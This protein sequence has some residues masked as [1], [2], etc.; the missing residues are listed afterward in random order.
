MTLGNP[1][2][3]I[4]SEFPNAPSRVADIPFEEGVTKIERLRRR[5]DDLSRQISGLRNEMRD[6]EG[7]AVDEMEMRPHLREAALHL[8]KCADL[9]GQL[10]RRPLSPHPQSL[11][12]SL[13]RLQGAE[14]QASLASNAIAQAR[15]HKPG[16]GAS[17]NL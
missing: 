4:V 8:E 16:E 10:E 15:L 14:T 13:G 17:F 2:V 9:M 5:I 11:K 7:H 6:L 12:G 1:E 3:R